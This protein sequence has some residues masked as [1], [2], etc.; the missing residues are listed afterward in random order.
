MPEPAACEQLHPD[1]L[2]NMFVDHSSK[3]F[4]FILFATADMLNLQGE[5]LFSVRMTNL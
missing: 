2:E 3:G 4:D 1:D 5:I